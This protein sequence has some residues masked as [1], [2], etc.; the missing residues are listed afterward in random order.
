M[1]TSHAEAART[2]PSSIYDE[3]LLGFAEGVAFDVRDS[4]K[5]RGEQLPDAFLNPGD[6]FARVLTWL[7]RH[8]ADDAVRV[9][10]TYVDTLMRISAD[11]RLTRQQVVD[12][13]RSIEGH[14]LTSAE[15]DELIRRLKRENGEDQ[16]S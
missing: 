3:L 4:L 6:P 1:V 9:A 14:Y 7:W 10:S 13:I 8:Y 11:E 5:R 16:S 12:G 2:L 15:V